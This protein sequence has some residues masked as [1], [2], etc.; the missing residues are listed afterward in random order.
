MTRARDIANIDGLLT[1]TGDTYYASAAAT[2]ARLGIGSTGQ[3]LTVSSGLPAWVTPSAA[4]S[5]TW[6][7]A[8]T[9]TLTGANVN[10][11]GLSGKRIAVFLKDFS[12]V[13][14]GAAKLMLN[15]QTSYYY[16]QAGRYS[17]T[18]ITLT[19]Y[20]GNGY[21]E[22]Y[23]GAVIDMAGSAMSFKPITVQ[24]IW[25]GSPTYPIG[26]WYG[27]DTNPITSVRLEGQGGWDAGTYYV[28]VE[29]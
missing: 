7:L 17:N 15:G 6:T 24:Q 1:T 20:I 8:A 12:L 28:Y 22:N 18:S 5:G 3:V 26:G 29:N 16:F 9:G 21:S 13:S 11:S 23:V 25:S 4:Y 2:P 19:S 10:V 27:P 14:D